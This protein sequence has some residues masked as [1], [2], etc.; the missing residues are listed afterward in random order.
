M[1]SAPPSSVVRLEQQLHA[2]AEPEHAARPASTR[3]RSS[4]SSASAR[5][6]SIAFGNA[7]TPGSTIA[8]RRAHAG[9]VA[10]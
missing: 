9:V 4:S 3:S 5:T 2:Q 10:A 8:V 1:P 6:S 7:P